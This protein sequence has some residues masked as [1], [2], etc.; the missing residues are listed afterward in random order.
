MAIF[1]TSVPSLRSGTDNFFELESG[2]GR[3]ESCSIHMLDPPI[4]DWLMIIFPASR[5]ADRGYPEEQTSGGEPRLCLSTAGEEND[6][7]VAE[8]ETVSEGERCG[9]SN[10]RGW[11]GWHGWHG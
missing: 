4:E 2:E 1:D 8:A 6:P 10:W 3:T 7:L 9:T 5:L 11:H